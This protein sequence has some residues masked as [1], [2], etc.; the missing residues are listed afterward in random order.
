MIVWL[1]IPTC[2]INPRQVKTTM[3]CEMRPQRD[4]PGGCYRS[5]EFTVAAPRRS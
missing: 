2:R 3:E 1:N 4:T 5:K